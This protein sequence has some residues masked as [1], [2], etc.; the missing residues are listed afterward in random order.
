LEVHVHV[1]GPAD[2]AGTAISALERALLLGAAHP[3]RPLQFGLQPVV[4]ANLTF[5][6][7]GA[8][9]ALNRDYRGIDAPT[10]VLSFSQLEGETLA[11]P[12]TGALE[13]GDVVISLDTARRQAAE[14]GHALEY[15]LALLAAHGGL[16]L[17]GYD[18]QADEDAAL[19]NALTRQVLSQLGYSNADARL[20]T[21]P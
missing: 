4:E 8:I 3:N 12:P 5:V 6:D 7:D 14:L 21:A 16:H 1:S 9:Q 2:A 18:H 17:L 15:E 13:A 20:G 10:D 19:I 11:P